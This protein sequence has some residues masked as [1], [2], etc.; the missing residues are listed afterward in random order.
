MQKLTC[1][2]SKPGEEHAWLVNSIQKMLEDANVKLASLATDITRVP[3]RTILATLLAQ[4][5]IV[6]LQKSDQKREVLNISAVQEVQAVLFLL[7]VLAVRIYK[8]G[9][10]TIHGDKAK[11]SLVSNY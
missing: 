3:R 2:L 11:P 1:Y 4:S 9:Q 8:R 6:S 10:R 7:R 5:V